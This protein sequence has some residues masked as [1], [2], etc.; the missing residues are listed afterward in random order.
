M[1]RHEDSNKERKE[2][3][4]FVYI[5]YNNVDFIFICSP[6]LAELPAKETG[7]NKNRN[8]PSCPVKTPPVALITSAKT[9]CLTDHFALH[10]PNRPFLHLGKSRRA[11]LVTHLCILPSS[12]SY[13]PELARVLHR[14][15]PAYRPLQRVL[16]PLPSFL[17]R[18]LRLPSS[19]SSSLCR[20]PY[21]SLAKLLM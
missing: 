6:L 21:L 14:R 16:F 20:S 4:L 18:L 9:R 2:K 17:K 13:T 12:P 3:Q 8:S 11:S 7:R 5:N 15:C 19:P 1:L 10:P